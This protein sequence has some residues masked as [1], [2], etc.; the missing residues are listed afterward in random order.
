MPNRDAFRKPSLRTPIWIIGAIAV[1]TAVGVGVYGLAQPGVDATTPSVTA[2]TTAPTRTT[3][4]E[5]TPVPVEAPELF[6][7]QA[8]QA[9][10][11]WDTTVDTTASVTERVMVWADPTG[12]EAPGLAADIALYLPS[13]DAWGVLAGYGTTQY[14]EILTI[15]VL[16]SWPGILASAAPGQILPGTTAYTIHA[17]R[18]RHGAVDGRA[19]SSARPVAFTVFVTCQPSF[20][21][22]HLMRISQPDTPLD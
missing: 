3:D 4:P 12:D 10:F 7:R 17:T 15:G 13:L 19:E 1:L 22:C 18:H 21:T 9:L 2:T 14:L 5:P 6:A 20:D 11:A 16:S 8:A